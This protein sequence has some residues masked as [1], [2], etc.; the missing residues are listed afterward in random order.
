MRLQSGSNRAGESDGPRS[1]ELSR[2]R[3]SYLLLAGSR[4]AV[5]RILILCYL[6]AN[7][8]NAN[9]LA[10]IFGLD[11]KTVKYH[12]R[13]LEEDELVAP[14]I[15]GGYGAVYFVSRSLES[16]GSL[17]DELCGKLKGEQTRQNG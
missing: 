16:K 17:L 4:G 1:S 14:S 3:I 8:V 6:R 10:G 7:P 12:L 13:L 5:T 2:R 9:R 11:Y 15:K